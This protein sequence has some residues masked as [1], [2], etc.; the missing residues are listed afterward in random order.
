MRHDLFADALSI[1]KNAEAVGKTEAVVPAN[2]VIK[3]FLE[4]L[5]N[6]NYIGS[7]EFV[8]DGKSG[9]FKVGL[10]GKINN[11]RAIKPRF[12][13]KAGEFEKWER[14][15]LPASGFGVLVVSTSKG[16]MTHEEAKE[17]NLGGRLLAFVY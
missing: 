17:K 9:F 15:F 8:D 14:R 5:K 6:E 3:N 12:A 11:C 10:I 13:V 16:I 1:I 7:Y 2:K 4:V